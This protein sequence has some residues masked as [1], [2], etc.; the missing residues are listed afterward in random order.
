MAERREQDLQT[1]ERREWQLWILAIVMITVLAA[2]LVLTAW[3]M[4][5]SG[6]ADRTQKAFL[7]LVVLTLLFNAYLIERQGKLK[8]LR[9]RL[10]E[11]EARNLAVALQ[12]C[13]TVLASLPGEEQFN[14]RLAM[15][16]KRAAA[17]SQPMSVVTFKI[18]M[19]ANTHEETKSEAWGRSA[20]LLLKDLKEGEAVYR[21]ADGVFCLLYLGCSRETA[22][23]ATALLGETLATD[24]HMMKLAVRIRT[25]VTTYPEDTQ[26]LHE[27]EQLAVR[28]LVS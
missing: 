14:D 3:P 2:G 28:G 22:E 16:L 11:S 9:R 18:E 6:Q 27:M 10:I 5:R 21:R 13:K 12:A 7:G 4:L 8:K 26:S 24:D 25:R 1:L 15:E 23:H 19:P 20:E 17:A